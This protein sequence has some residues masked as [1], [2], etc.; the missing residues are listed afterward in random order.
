MARTVSELARV[1]G[2]SVRTLHHYDA[3]GLLRPTGRTEAGYRLYGQ[4]DLERLQQILFFRE[5]QMPL[6]EIRRVLDDPSFDR[7]AALRMQRELLR[8]RRE[9]VDGAL[10]LVERALEAMET[11]ETMSDEQMFQGLNPHEDEARE[12]WGDTDAWRESQRR[13]KKYGKDDWARM[14]AEMDAIDRK[15][16]EL[17]AAGRAPADPEVQAAAEEHRLHIDRW[18]YPCSRSMHRA[19][20]EMYVADPRFAERYER[21]QPGL[22]AFLRD[23]LVAADEA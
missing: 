8:E 2:V 20:G 12:R 13:T 6:P 23:A 3:I 15:L 10:Q 19:L 1:A 17:L 18:F 7:R 11:G 5:L 9:A 4:A 14:R 22:A 21:I 16:G